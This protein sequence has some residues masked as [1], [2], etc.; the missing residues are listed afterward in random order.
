MEA[1]SQP[2]ELT[3]E[4]HDLILEVVG[5]LRHSPGCTVEQP[6]EWCLCGLETLLGEWRRL[7][8]IDAVRCRG[9]GVHAING[10]GTEDWAWREDP[11]EP[12]CHGCAV[13]LMERQER[14][15]RWWQEAPR[16]LW[17]LARR[18]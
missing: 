5:H 6:G 9:C 10:D 12:F 17:R 4:A 1:E 16:S 8:R 2:P 14:E 11:L 3:D 18:G 13:G 15:R 7:Y